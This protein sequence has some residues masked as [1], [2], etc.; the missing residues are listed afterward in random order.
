M[1]YPIPK[2]VEEIIALGEEPVNE[3]VVAAAIA[4]VIEIARSQGQ[5][6]DEL[7]TLVLAD[8]NLLDLAQRQWLSQALE[9]A[10]QN[11]PG[12]G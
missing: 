4:G 2:N 9:E 11:W 6:L 8:D 10:W 7:Q 1:K 12:S 5:S 3:E